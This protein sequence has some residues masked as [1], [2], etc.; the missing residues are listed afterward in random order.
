M[1]GREISSELIFC[2]LP[3]GGDE[4]IFRHDEIRL[5]QSRANAPASLFRF[6]L[7]GGAESTARMPIHSSAPICLLCQQPMHVARTI[8]AVARLP[9][10]LVFHCEGCGEVETR[11]RGHAAC[12][13]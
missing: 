5:K 7:F 4:T 9:E 8:P 6:F 1:H 2:N 13:R 12:L 10:V 11:E 3:G